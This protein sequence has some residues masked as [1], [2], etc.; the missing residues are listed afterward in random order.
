MTVLTCTHKVP[1]AALVAGK[2]YWDEA[3]LDHWALLRHGV[4][5]AEAHTLQ[6]LRL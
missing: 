5:S 1:L 6:A 4:P 2:G 3:P